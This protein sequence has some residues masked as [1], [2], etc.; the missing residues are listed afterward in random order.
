MKILLTRLDRV[1][2]LVLSTPAIASVRRSWPQ[3]H[4]TLACSRYNAVVVAR[5]PDVDALAILEPS[6]DPRRFGADLAG[7]LDLAIALAPRTLDFRVVGASR[8]RRRIG[9][10]YVRRYATRLFARRSLTDLVISEADPDLAERGR[11]YPVRHEVDQILGLVRRA[12]GETV[13]HELVLPIDDRDRAAVAQVP[14][15]AIAVQL[16]PR[17]LSKGSTLASALALFGELRTLGRP[18]LATFGADAR[19]FGTRVREAGVA[20][21]VLG[22]LAFGAWAAAFEKS[23]VVLTVDTGATHVASA[24]RRPTVV[25]FEHQYFNLNSQ[26]WAPYRVPAVCLRKPAGEG[27]AELAGSRAEIVAAVGSLLN[28]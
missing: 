24:A 9:Y 18:L 20:D 28:V 6:A 13:A 4:V 23:A 25:L 5:N 22:D 10:T 16:A 14:F 21:I 15:G 7:D 11:R 8:A 26:E 19:E 27:A 3:A 1:G 12:G 17:W 2:D